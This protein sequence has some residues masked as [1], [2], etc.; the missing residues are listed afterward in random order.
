LSNL[1]PNSLPQDDGIDYS[2]SPQ[3]LCKTAFIKN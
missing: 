3:L 2:I 1:N